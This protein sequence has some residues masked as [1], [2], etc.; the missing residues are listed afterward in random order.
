L[1]WHST[2][3]TS[4]TAV[5]LKSRNGLHKATYVL[6]AMDSKYYVGFADDSEDEVHINSRSNIILTEETGDLFNAPENSVLVHACNAS[7]SWGAG[8]AREFLRRYTSS[9]I[10]YKDFCKRENCLGKCFLV[11]STGCDGS[12]C[13]I[14]CL[15]VS[16]MYGKNR[17]SADDIIANTKL[18][19][20]DL[21]RKLTDMEDRWSEIRMCRIN[22][23]YF[24]VQWADTKAAIMSLSTDKEWMIHVINKSG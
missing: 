18:A 12:K 21:F 10:K 22:S 14:A 9:Y 5:P 3:F 8:I 16:R 13:Y 17:D 7:G 2:D 19:M 23:G 11:Q 24:G 6:A 15:I 20:Q 1:P 4:I